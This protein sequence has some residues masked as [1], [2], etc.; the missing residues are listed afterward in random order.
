MRRAGRTRAARL[1]RGA[2]VTSGLGQ[3]D[4]LIPLTSQSTLAEPLQSL[5]AE[6]Q[7]AERSRCCR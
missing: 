5:M 3:A 7:A 2:T 4:F 6:V 1:L